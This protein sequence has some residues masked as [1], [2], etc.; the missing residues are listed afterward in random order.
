MKMKRFLALLMAVL[1]CLSGC[2]AE[3]A[4]SN[5]MANGSVSK[6]EGVYDSVATPEMEAGDRAAGVQN[7]KLIRTVSIDAETENMDSLLAQLDAKIQALGG[8]VES[9]SISNT[10]R[11]S[12]RKY[13]YANMTIRVPV[14]RLDEFVTHIDGAS[15]VTASRESAEDVTLSYVA[16][17]SRITALET[18]QNRLLELLAMAENMDDLLMIEQRLTDVRTELEEVT[19][20]LKLY[21][22]LVDYGTVNLQITEVVEFTVEEEETV[23]Q[24]ISGGFMKNLQ[25]LWDGIV[26]LFIAL[27]VNIPYLLPLA[28]VA[29]GIVIAIK[30]SKA[31]RAKQEDKDTE[32]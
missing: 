27:V 1:L 24:R 3:S 30:R 12:N 22:N 11:Y 13:R 18:E 20:R 14:A 6:G 31:K 9:K 32:A 19:S 17:Q 16:T 21:D 7:Q 4:G 5:A 28:A 2:G 10:S 26:E 8:Y 25:G 23:W 15:N 29:I